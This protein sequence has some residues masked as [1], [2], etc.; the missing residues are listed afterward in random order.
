MTASSLNPLSHM[1]MQAL[2]RDRSFYGYAKQPQINHPLKSAILTTSLE[3][4]PHIVSL[5]RALSKEGII[6]HTRDPV[7]L[8]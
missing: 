1:T 5:Q 6:P 8:N 3:L 2:G 4:Q 7:S